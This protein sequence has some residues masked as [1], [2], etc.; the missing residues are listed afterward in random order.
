MCVCASMTVCMH[1]WMRGKDKGQILNEIYCKSNLYNTIPMLSISLQQRIGSDHGQFQWLTMS[2][3]ESLKYL[4][5]S[6][7]CLKSVHN[8]SNTIA[9]STACRKQID[10]N[11]TVFIV[12]NNIHMKLSYQRQVLQYNT[13]DQDGEHDNGRG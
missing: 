5:I 12:C 7:N 2:G 11:I 4:T 1:G 6:L 9:A 10:D 3:L 13:Q 8:A